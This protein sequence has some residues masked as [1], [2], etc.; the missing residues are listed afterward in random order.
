[1]TLATSAP[2]AFNRDFSE[3]D[4]SMSDQSSETESMSERS[5]FD[6]NSSTP[7]ENDS[8]RA[9]SGASTPLSDIFSRAEDTSDDEAFLE[10]PPPRYSG[11]RR[12]GLRPIRIQG[13]TPTSAPMMPYY[14]TDGGPAFPMRHND[15]GETT[16]GVPHRLEVSQDTP[17][18]QFRPSGSSHL[19]QP[20]SPWAS[21]SPSP[22]PSNQTESTLDYCPFEIEEDWLEGGTGIKVPDVGSGSR[23]RDY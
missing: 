19:P 11:R 16:A 1:M 9:T 5:I 10:T 13:S 7:T 17:M 8:S 12:R 18:D 21:R 14:S 22:S 4:E 23:Q 3:T 2:A 20:N 6:T 15:G